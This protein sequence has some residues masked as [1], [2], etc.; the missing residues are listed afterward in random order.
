M[1]ICKV[2]LTDEKKEV[3]RTCAK[4][5]TKWAIERFLPDRDPAEA[6]AVY[7]YEFYVDLAKREMDDTWGQTLQKGGTSREWWL[8]RVASRRTAIAFLNWAHSAL[9]RGEISDEV[10]AQMYHFA[11]CVAP[12]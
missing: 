6:D 2:K 5:S 9:E 8:A 4:D 1:S 7:P 3:I 12:D 11:A 10:L